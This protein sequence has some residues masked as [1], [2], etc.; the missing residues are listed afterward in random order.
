MHE[1]MM[2]FE[3]L[4][5]SEDF[6]RSNAIIFFTKIDIFREKILTGLSPVNKHFPDYHGRPTDVMAAQEF[7]ADKFRN[8]TRQHEKGCYIQFV[9]TT[10]TDILKKLTCSV[11]DAIVQRNLNALVIRNPHH[12]IRSAHRKQTRKSA[13]TY[14]LQGTVRRHK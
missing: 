7:F 6:S 14:V 2:L 9:N 12:R 5:N 10:D 3:S 13:S 8:L 1:A 4:L 11:H